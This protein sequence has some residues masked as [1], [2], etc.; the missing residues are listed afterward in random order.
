MLNVPAN[1]RGKVKAAC[2]L[3]QDRSADPGDPEPEA[4]G[5]HCAREPIDDPEWRKLEKAANTSSHTLKEAAQ[6][7]AADQR[8]AEREDRRVR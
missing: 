7:G 6:Q 5:Q 2:P 3:Q 1:A 8:A 4:G